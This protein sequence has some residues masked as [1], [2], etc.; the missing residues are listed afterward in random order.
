M[1]PPRP[2][3]RVDIRRTASRQ[4]S[5]VPSTLTASIRRTRSAVSSSTRARAPTMPAFATRAASGPRESAAEKAASTSAS[6][7]TSARTGTA[8]PPSASIPSATA[9]AAAASSR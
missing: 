8:T 3:R 5:T 1:A 7:E 6:T 9:A 4:H 2:P